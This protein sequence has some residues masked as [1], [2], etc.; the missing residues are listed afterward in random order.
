MIKAIIFD[1]GGVLVRTEE[2]HFRKELEAELGLAPGEAEFLVFNSEQGLKA[3]R[4]E[5]TTAELWSG[6]QDY[7]GFDPG[8]VEDF[9]HRFFAGDR[10]DRELVDFIRQL[11]GQCQ[12]AIIS[13]AADNLLDNVTRVY[14]MADAFELI[15]G[16]AYEKIMKPDPTIFL[17]T[18]E[19]LNRQPRECLFIDD[20]LHNVEAAQAIGMQAI[21]FHPRIDLEKELYERLNASIE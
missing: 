6:I 13:N 1:V 15:V 17:R 20:F 7:F 9:R 8:Q 4:G 10:L 18:V 21:H 16:S 12:T 14:P 19:R 5:I 3:Q 2:P 11:R